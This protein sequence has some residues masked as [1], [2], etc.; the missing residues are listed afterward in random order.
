MEITP[1]LHQPVELLHQQ[2]F[3]HS[4]SSSTC[5]TASST[6]IQPLQ[7]FI[8]MWNR[9]INRH[10]TT[11]SLHQHVEPLHQ[12]HLTTPS[13]SSTGTEAVQIFINGSKFK[14][15][16]NYLQHTCSSRATATMREPQQI[17]STDCALNF[18]Q[19][20]QPP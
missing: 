5:G 15:T 11:P 9:F 20:V 13:H 6:D 1:S 2:T 7:V 14:P 16:L 3:N 18:H 10:L 12:R 19:Q 4:K 8:T 17:Y